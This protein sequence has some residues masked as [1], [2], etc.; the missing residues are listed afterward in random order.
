M[1]RVPSYISRSR[2]SIDTRAGF[3]IFIQ[4]AAENILSISLR[5]VIFDIPSF[6][7]DINFTIHEI[8]MFI[9]YTYT[10]VYWI[11]V[12]LFGGIICR[13][14][15]FVCLLFR[16]CVNNVHNSSRSSFAFM[17]VNA[18]STFIRFHNYHHI[19][20]IIIVNAVHNTALQNVLRG[21]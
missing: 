8:N 4:S 2:H 11:I 13:I 17:S 5:F 1:H 18:F 3:V 6:R 16:N 7:N 10:Y 14:V 12:T 20:V 9:Y 15:L 21:I 19:I